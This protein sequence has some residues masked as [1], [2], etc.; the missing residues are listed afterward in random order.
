LQKQYH[1]DLYSR[2]LDLVKAQHQKSY[3]VESCDELITYKGC[4]QNTLDQRIYKVTS[5]P[6]L[7]VTTSSRKKKLQKPNMNWAGIIAE[8][9][10]NAA[11]CF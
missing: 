1:P 3:I 11:R 4:H 9:F 8:N 2:L 10:Y 7:K 6:N 5:G